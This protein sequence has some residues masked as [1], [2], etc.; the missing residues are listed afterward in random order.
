[1][2]NE[3]DPSWND[4]ELNA[5]MGNLSDQAAGSRMLHPRPLER[6]LFGDDQHLFGILSHGEM[7]KKEITEQAIHLLHHHILNKREANAAGVYR[8]CDVL[9]LANKATTWKNVPTE[10]KDFLQWANANEPN[11]DIAR[12]AA[13]VH[14]KL[15]NDS[16]GL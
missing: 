14:H 15:V 10:M 16:F 4:D 6:S 5:H 1:M 12:F 7:Q 13:Q 3:F 8:V 9:V 11:E 2:A